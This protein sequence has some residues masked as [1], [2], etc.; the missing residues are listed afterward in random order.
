MTLDK[1]LVDNPKKFD[2]LI[3]SPKG[4]RILE[5]ATQL[6]HERGFDAVTVQ[7]VADKVGMLKGSLYHYIGS[8][9]DLLF[10][11][12]YEMHLEAMSRLSKVKQIKG[13]PKEVLRMFIIYHFIDAINL[14]EKSSV[15]YD[16]FKRLGEK[17]RAALTQEASEYQKF[18]ED[19]INAGKKDK[20]FDKKLNTRIAVNSMMVAL[21]SLHR[22]YHKD[23]ELTAEELAGA[24]A[25]LILK[26]ISA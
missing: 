25:D 2:L 23:D 10:A 6:I 19:L 5:V 16:N 20:L 14:L 11:I 4:R 12:L 21:T 24:Y 15:Y 9:E 7:D 13:S 22:W 3:T 1:K 18:A 17:K 8:K 26:G